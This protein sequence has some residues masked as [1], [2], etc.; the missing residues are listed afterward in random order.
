VRV[1]EDLELILVVNDSRT[2][3]SEDGRRLTHDGLEHR[4]EGS[5]DE[6]VDLSG[7]QG[8]VSKRRKTGKRWKEDERRWSSSRRAKRGQGSSR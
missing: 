6:S 1:V 2:S 7:A 5:E 8:L 4:L 3:L